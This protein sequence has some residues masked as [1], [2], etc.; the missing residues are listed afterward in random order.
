[1]AYRKQNTIIKNYLKSIFVI[2]L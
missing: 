1:M 2:I